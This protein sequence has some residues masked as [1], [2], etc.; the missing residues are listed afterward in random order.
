MRRRSGLARYLLQTPVGS[1]QGATMADASAADALRDGP[2]RGCQRLDAVGLARLG[3]RRAITDAA[4]LLEP[5][6]PA[7]QLDGAV[8]ALVAQQ[9]RCGWPTTRRHGCGSDGAGGVCGDRSWHPRPRRRPAE[10]DGRQCALR[11]NGVVAN[12]SPSRRR[13]CGATPVNRLE[14]GVAT[15]SFSTPT[16]CRRMHPANSQRFA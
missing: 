16:R 4:L 9:C 10:A 8:R 14:G 11:L 15:T 13:R 12:A 6:A 7:E 1:A 3:R 5:H 2:V